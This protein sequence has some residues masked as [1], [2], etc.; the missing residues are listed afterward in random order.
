MNLR[1]DFSTSGKKMFKRKTN[2]SKLDVKKGVKVIDDDPA[3]HLN[4]T[5]KQYINNKLSKN[6][7]GENNNTNIDSKII[8]NLSTFVP[9]FKDKENCL[10]RSNTV[11]DIIK[12]RNLFS[13]KKNSKFKKINY[14][15]KSKSNSGKKMIKSL[16]SNKFNL[17][18]SHYKVIINRKNINLNLNKINKN[19][20]LKK[21]SINSTQKYIRYSG[22]T[23]LSINDTNQL[24]EKNSAIFPYNNYNSNYNNNILLSNNST[25]E[26]NNLKT[27]IRKTTD[28]KN[29]YTMQYYT[30]NNYYNY[31]NAKNK[32]KKNNNN[33]CLVKNNKNVNN[34]NSQN[35]MTSD[36]NAN[37]KSIGSYNQH[38]NNSNFKNGSNNINNPSDI[39]KDDNTNNKNN[40]NESSYTI[41][42]MKNTPQ[43]CNNNIFGI[44]NMNNMNQ[45]INICS[46]KKIE[47]KVNKEYLKTD[48]SFE[49]IKRIEFL[50]NENKLLKGE[51]SESKNKLLLLE[52]KINK[53][54][55]EKNSIEKDE[56]PRPTPYV[57]KYS[58]ETLQ[59]IQP[60]PSIDI[61]INNSEIQ[62]KENE[63]KINNNLNEKIINENSDKNMVKK[64][65][66]N[67]V[68]KYIYQPTNNINEKQKINN[69]RKNK[70][71]HYIK[72]NT[73][74]KN[75]IN[76]NKKYKKIS[77]NKIAN[78]INDKKKMWKKVNNMK[79]L[80]DKYRFTHLNFYTE[81]NINNI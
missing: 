1:N 75:K 15:S 77:Y 63:R 30:Q 24:L 58:L 46:T 51:I 45:S 32:D 10:S 41:S 3:F 74:T 33:I 25:L 36:G 71:T 67:K 9:K 72:N 57:K 48:N 61:N 44:N 54:L 64:S 79:Q 13:I 28:K 50:E 17:N 70:S 40:N 62:K 73:N 31:T 39:Y 12:K 35:N 49:Y 21:N 14:S 55:I 26:I 47:D 23:A 76:V 65:L 59:N 27:P 68:Q 42:N 78:N 18:L 11:A 43:K 4:R 69:L 53:L 60:S 52:N 56:C 37:L 38:I 5:L 6:I 80:V 2:Y 29:K 19:Q 81:G 7:S 34:K 16:S 8:N 22:S 66:V 20:I